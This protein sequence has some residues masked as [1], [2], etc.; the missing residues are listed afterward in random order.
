VWRPLIAVYAREIQG[1]FRL[2]RPKVPKPYF[3]SCARLLSELLANAG[4]CL[5]NRALRFPFAD[6]GAERV[7]RANR[8]HGNELYAISG[9]YYDK[10]IAHNHISNADV[11]WLGAFVKKADIP[12]GLNLER[13][14]LMDGFNNCRH[15]SVQRSRIPACR[16]GCYGDGELATE[17]LRVIRTAAVG[18]RSYA[19][20]LPFCAPMTGRVV[21]S[22]RLIAPIV[23]S[24]ALLNTEDDEDAGMRY[25]STRV[26][27]PAA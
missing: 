13:G 22:M 14:S 20:E 27:S 21:A 15:P 23:P 16:G 5:G 9:P 12:A 6:R 24:V 2:P 8:F 4:E 18:S 7:D 19:G 11:I 1:R 17:T 26:V 3:I 10:C 25:A